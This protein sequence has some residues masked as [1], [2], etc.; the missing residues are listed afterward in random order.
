MTS[1]D[2]TKLDSFFENSTQEESKFSIN[3]G[4][5]SPRWV[6]HKNISGNG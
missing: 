5:C 2:S 3:T 4:V 1:K 6:G